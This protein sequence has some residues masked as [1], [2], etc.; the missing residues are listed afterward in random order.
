[1]NMGTLRL[2]YGKYAVDVQT[3]GV[4]WL[5]GVEKMTATRTEPVDRLRNFLGKKRGGVDV[6]ALPYGLRTNRE[7]FHYLVDQKCAMVF[8]GPLN[9][10]DIVF[11]YAD[12]NA[13]CLVAVLA[14]NE[15]IRVAH[16][17]KKTEDCLRKKLKEAEAREKAVKEELEAMRK[18]VVAVT[19]RERT[20]AWQVALK[21]NAEWLHRSDFLLRG[22]Q[23]AQVHSEK[24]QE[25]LSTV[26][27]MLNKR[28]GAKRVKF[29]N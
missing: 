8:E 22:W 18:E 29:L 19:L 5:K 11:V 6:A 21:R 23:A 20:N 24:L 4:P 1:M 9:K 13:Q 7:V 17:E 27:E 26:L 14:T 16:T 12:E 25:N 28:E 3:E 10:K 2:Q 15:S